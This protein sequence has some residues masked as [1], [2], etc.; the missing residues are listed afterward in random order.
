MDHS[1]RPRTPEDDQVEEVAT[2]EAVLVQRVLVPPSRR[3][4]SLHQQPRS[5]DCNEVAYIST[6]P[7]P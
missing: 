2:P 5:N 1:I 3:I 6:R 4:G 7:N